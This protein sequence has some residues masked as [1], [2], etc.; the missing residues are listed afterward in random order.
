[1]K[2]FLKGWCLKK[3]ENLT[4]QLSMRLMLTVCE[5]CVLGTN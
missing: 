1:M 4:I 2:V 5:K 3:T